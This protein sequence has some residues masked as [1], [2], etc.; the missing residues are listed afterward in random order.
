MSKTAHFRDVLAWRFD[1]EPKAYRPPPVSEPSLLVRFEIEPCSAPRMTRLSAFKPTPHIRRY[2]AFKD[3]IGRQVL[4][5]LDAK[6]YCLSD[7][8]G[9]LG[10]RFSVS[11]SP[12]WSEKKK[13]QLAGARHE[14]SPDFDNF[15]KG[16][17]DALFLKDCRVWD[18]RVQKRWAD[19]SGPGIEVWRVPEWQ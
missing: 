6:Y 18:V 3:E 15:A 1:L 13:R 14:L 7:L 17:F 4:A 5:H 8:L 11:L 2:M 12:S 9:P 10:L 16:F 19:S